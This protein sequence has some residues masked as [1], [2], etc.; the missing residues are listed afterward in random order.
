[1]AIVIRNFPILKVLRKRTHAPCGS[2]QAGRARV[3][4]EEFGKHRISVV[5]S[6]SGN[7]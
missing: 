5:S 6:G 3:A 2:K 1:M 7:S 4:V